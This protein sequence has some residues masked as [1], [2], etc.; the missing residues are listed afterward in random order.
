MKTQYGGNKEIVTD[1]WFCPDDIE[2]YVKGTKYAWVL[3]WPQ[4]PNF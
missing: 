1:F 2:L 4:V 3:N